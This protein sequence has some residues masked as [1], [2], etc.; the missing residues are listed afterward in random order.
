MQ[1]I[2]LEDHLEPLEPRSPAQPEKL[3]VPK[4]ALDQYFTQLSLIEDGTDRIARALVW[5]DSTI[6]NDGIIKDVRGRMQERFGDS[7]P[8]FLAAKVD[9]RW[10]F[11]RDI[12]RNVDGSWSAKNIVHGGAEDSRYGLAGTVAIAHPGAKST[13]GGVKIEGE[14]QNIHRFQVFYQ[15]RPLGGDL[16]ISAKKQSLNTCQK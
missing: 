9:K 14:R 8:G 16:N 5:G 4:G 12:V 2:P 3:H 7:G 13:L 6:A 11:R 10:A 1:V 15:R